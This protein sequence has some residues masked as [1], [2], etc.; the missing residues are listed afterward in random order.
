MKELK[1][2]FFISNFTISDPIGVMGF[3]HKLI[4]SRS[5]NRLYYDGMLYDKIFMSTI[6]CV[7]FAYQKS[8]NPGEIFAKRIADLITLEIWARIN[9]GFVVPLFKKWFHYLRVKKYSIAG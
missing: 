4:V 8:S 6:V 7:C 2:S 9:A 3:Y 1:S 5:N